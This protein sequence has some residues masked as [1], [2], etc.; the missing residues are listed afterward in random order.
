MQR[1]LVINPGKPGQ[2]NW[3]PGVV[4]RNAQIKACLANAAAIDSP[5]GY[6]TPALYWP[7]HVEDARAVTLPPAAEAAAQLAGFDI[8]E[9]GLTG[10]CHLPLAA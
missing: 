5:D 8:N 3:N 6:A 2:A 1:W 7:G 4:P 10:S 9:C